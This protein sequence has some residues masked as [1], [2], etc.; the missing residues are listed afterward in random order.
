MAE[1]T[2]TIRIRVKAKEHLDELDGMMETIKTAMVGAGFMV[3]KGGHNQPT[4]DDPQS[5]YRGRYSEFSMWG[6]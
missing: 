3:T 5:P 4:E 1:L 6:S 2:T